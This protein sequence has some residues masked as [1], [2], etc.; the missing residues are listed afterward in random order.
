M[1]IHHLVCIMAVIAIPG[2]KATGGSLSPEISAANATEAAATRAGHAT[3][4]Q[5]RSTTQAPDKVDTKTGA[6]AAG[7]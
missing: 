5:Y 4:D 2:S 7:K 1:K 3:T 6:D